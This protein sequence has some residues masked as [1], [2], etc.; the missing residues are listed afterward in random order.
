MN[1]CT[2]CGLDRNELVEALRGLCDSVMGMAEWLHDMDRPAIAR[3]LRV[4]VG[5]AQGL[6]AKL[7]VAPS[8]PDVAASPADP[9]DEAARIAALY[10]D[11]TSISGEA[12]AE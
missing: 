8:V 12:L 5:V 4:D 10:A 1:Q 6:L 2:A 7:A 11:R 3:K 9:N